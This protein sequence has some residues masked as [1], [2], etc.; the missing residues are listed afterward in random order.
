MIDILLWYFLP[1]IFIL[2]TGIKEPESESY[3]IGAFL[4]G[5]NLL[6]AVFCVG[7][8]FTRAWNSKGKCTLGHK[9]VCTYDSEKEKWDKA[10]AKGYYPRLSVGGSEEYICECCGTKR[11]V[12]WSA[13]D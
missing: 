13:F 2:F 10:R 5:I 9:F 6:V 11:A 1:L 7:E 3:A 12:H 8:I 4:P